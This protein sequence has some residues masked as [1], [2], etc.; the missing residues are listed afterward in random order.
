MKMLKFEKRTTSYTIKKITK[1]AIRT[2]YFTF[3][4]RNREWT[5]PEL[6][7]LQHSCAH[8]LFLSFHQVA[9]VSYLTSSEVYNYSS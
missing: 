1:I 8:F 4:R 2:S 6:M 9:I 7:I 3:C 5:D